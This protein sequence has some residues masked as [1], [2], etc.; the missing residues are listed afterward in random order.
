MSRKG[1]KNGQSK[2]GTFSRKDKAKRAEAE[3]ALQKEH[4]E[5]R[6]IYY[7]KWKAK[8]HAQDP[9][10]LRKSQAA[11]RKRN[12]KSRLQYERA[13]SLKI[14][15]EVMNAYGGAC[16]CC[17]ESEIAFLAL[18]H[19]NN[20]GAH[21]RKHLGDTKGAQFYWSLKK[22]G[23]PKGYLQVHCHN[24]NAAKQYYGECPHQ[25]NARVLLKLV[26]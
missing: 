20:D 7:A 9:D 3:K 22:A 2:Y 17:G 26:S 23:F 4:P 1:T 10:S 14:K 11:S 12:R 6:K 25:T 5:R 21:R 13:R 15:R 16:S 8:K 24:C 18:D 19:I